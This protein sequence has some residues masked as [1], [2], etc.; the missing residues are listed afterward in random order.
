[1][2]GVC[3]VKTKNLIIFPFILIFYEIITYLSNDL[4]LPALTSLMRD[5]NSTPAMAQLTLTAWFLGSASTQLVM[6]PLSDRYGRRPILLSGAIIFILSTILCAATD[7]MTTLLIARF[8]QG[9]AV[10]SFMVAGYATVHELYDTHKAIHVL[11]LMGSIGILAPAFGPLLGGFILQIASWRYLFWSLAIGAVIATILLLKWMPESNPKEN[12]LPLLFKNILYSYYLIIKNK[13]FMISTIVL[14][15][16]Y[17]GLIAWLTM[18]P[19]LIT[20]SYQ[21]SPLMFGVFQALIF[22]TFIVGNMLVKYVMKYFTINKTILIGLIITLIGSIISL[23]ASYYDSQHIIS[24]VIA[25]MIFAGG[26]ALQYGTLQRIAIEASREAMGL[27]MAIFSSCLGIAGVLSSAISSY[28][29]D[30]TSIRLAYF[31]LIA[32]II[33]LGLNF[34]RNEKSE[35]I[36]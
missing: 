4:Y 33:S 27:R 1:M 36:F 12:R 35:D 32:A 8:I 23:T 14:C 17:G 16:I 24:F 11:A 20:E 22:S 25:L 31:L 26:S 5:F 28:I 18:G 10:C 21:Y 13:N 29:Y 2:A 9:S 7:S 34:L 19:L 3:N 6:G 15:L 30:G